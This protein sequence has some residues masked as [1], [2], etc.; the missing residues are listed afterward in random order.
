MSLVICGGLRTIAHQL[1][2][3][4][5]GGGGGCGDDDNDN[6]LMLIVVA[7]IT[8]AEQCCRYAVNR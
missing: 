6:G 1:A 8:M 2:V 4:V 7:L 3:L 5:W